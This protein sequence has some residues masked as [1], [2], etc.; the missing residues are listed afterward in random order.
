MTKSMTAFARVEHG[1]AVWELRSVNHRYLDVSFRMPENVR[2]LE[3]DLKAAFKD[4]IQRGKVE[5]SLKIDAAELT[6]R[7]V[8]NEPLVHQLHQAA[9]VIEEMTGID[10]IGDAMSV[11]RWPDVLTTQAD[12]EGLIDDVSNGFAMGVEQLAEM[13]AREGAELAE[14]IESRL[15]DVEN[16]VAGLRTEVPLII[17]SQREKLAKRIED[18]GVEVDGNR[19][20]QEVVMMAQK[21][22]V[23]EELDRLT[24]HVQEVRRNLSQ[25]DPV[26]RR[27][28]FLMQEL[29]REANTLSS[30]SAAAST[31]TSAVDLKVV[32]EQMREQIQNIE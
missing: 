17:R 8:V 4:V 25:S 30:K 20:E 15:V 22:D 23:D 3:N 11:L 26:G 19:L 9:A 16:T 29:N 1:A 2:Y 21:M 12:S 5:C 10:K 31:T 32:I 28:D 14:L 7:Y 13:R 6:T 24:T 18:L 27:L